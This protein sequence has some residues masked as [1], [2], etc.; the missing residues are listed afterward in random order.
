MIAP[1]VSVI[2]PVHNVD[3]Y[4]GR[5]IESLQ[6]Q[7]MRELEFIFV[8]DCSTDGSLAQAEAW[9]A[10][11]G[12]VRIVRNEE[13]L[14]AGPSRNRGIEEAR[15]DYLS[16]VDPDD[17]VSPDFYEL[18]YAAATA[19]DGHDMAKGTREIVGMGGKPSR[20]STER[21]NKRI[22]D[23]LQNNIPLFTAFSSEHQSAI[24][25]HS[26]FDRGARNGT[27]RKDEDTTFLL[28]ACLLSEDIVVEED[29]VYHYVMR[30]GSS[31]S[32]YQ[33]ES[34]MGELD[35]IAERAALLEGRRNERHAMGYLRAKLAIRLTNYYAG[36][37]YDPSLADALDE[38]A[39]K[40]AGI[41]DRLPALGFI[42]NKSPYYGALID[43]H[44]LLPLAS[45]LPEELKVEGA[46]DWMDF[47]KQTPRVR[48]MYCNACAKAQETAL[49]HI[50]KSQGQHEYMLASQQTLQEINELPL[51]PRSV[52]LFILSDHHGSKNPIQKAIGI[53]GRRRRRKGIGVHHNGA[54]L[55]IRCDIAERIE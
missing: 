18:L 10:E 55:H 47:I 51:K 19:Q 30:P 23:A 29:A 48:L 5:C 13:N 15:G 24:Y 39:Q 50:K 20:A 33:L 27:S 28:S 32:S 31:V 38:Y 36:I 21:V 46:R 54:D 26:L 53:I 8:D 3:P 37:H 44:T 7:T 11:D 34:L 2:L 9:A 41:V 16:F 40:L 42:K 12:R 6:A 14:G 17:Y 52:I 35:S 49:R 45:S 1:K 43:H 25:R 4:I 22:R